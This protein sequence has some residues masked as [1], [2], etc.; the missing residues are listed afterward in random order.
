MDNS[1]KNIIYLL[2]GYENSKRHF[3]TKLLGIYYT[4]EEIQKR[5]DEIC[6]DESTYSID[7][8]IT[9]DKTWTTFY[10]QYFYGDNCK[11][12]F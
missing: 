10:R 9:R 7:G 2:F 12:L 4:L 8:N 1:S 6:L 3:N 5:Q 11:E